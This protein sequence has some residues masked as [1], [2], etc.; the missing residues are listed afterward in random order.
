METL[1]KYKDFGI[2]ASS[3]GMHAVAFDAT[4]MTLDEVIALEGVFVHPT[5]HPNSFEIFAL[6][7]TLEQYLEFCSQIA[8]TNAKKQAIIEFDWHPGKWAWDSEEQAA[9][10]NRVIELY[11]NFKPWYFDV[12]A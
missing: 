6:K 9:F 10:N 5:I 8:D 11:T 1:I 7:G 4:T 12:M 3:C 2:S